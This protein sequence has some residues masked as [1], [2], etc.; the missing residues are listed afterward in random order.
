MGTFLETP[1]STYVQYYTGPVLLTRLPRLLPVVKSNPRV[2]GPGLV[3]VGPTL[4]FLVE[5][6]LPSRPLKRTNSGM[7]YSTSPTRRN[8]PHRAERRSVPISFSSRPT[9]SG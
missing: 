1:S 8:M 9:A 6:M 5:L 3:G 2:D 7:P 4:P